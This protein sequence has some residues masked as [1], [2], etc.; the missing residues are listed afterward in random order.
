M[1][2]R[3]K[4]IADEAADILSRPPVETSPPPPERTKSVTGTCEPAASLIRRLGGAHEVARGIR[5][6][7]ISRRGDR[8]DVQMNPSS[9]LRW[10]VASDRGGT[11]GVIPLSHWPAI[12]LLGKEK[13]ITVTIND[14]SE[15]VARAL[16]E[17]TCQAS[18]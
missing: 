9:V 2:R 4:S 7:S 11:G 1:P 14:L 6:L 12:I 16:R 17:A 13:G 15:R 8:R 3:G 18:S 5:Q 10:A